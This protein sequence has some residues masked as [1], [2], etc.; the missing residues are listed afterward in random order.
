[1]FGELIILEMQKYGFQP[2]PTR[3]A[4]RILASKRLIE[5]PHSHFREI[6]VPASEDPDKFHFRAT[7]I[8]IYHS[9]YWI[10][11][12]QFLDA[13]S[14]DTPIFEDEARA[15][16]SHLA[17]SF[18][19]DARYKKVVAFTEYLEACWHSMDVVP[20]YYDFPTILR[21]QNDSFLSVE[22]AIRRY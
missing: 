22:R 12:F 13:V 20:D 16:V 1:M 3:S 6:V 14:S 8:G 18:Q 15:L 19:I 10:G 4:L 17:P 2:D 21:N 11:T 5:T 7:S 9:R